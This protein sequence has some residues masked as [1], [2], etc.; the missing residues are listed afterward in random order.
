[1][2]RVAWMLSVCLNLVFMGIFT[3]PNLSPF[4]A[5]CLSGTSIEEKANQQLPRLGRSL[6]QERRR[7][8]FREYLE[9][10]SEDDLGVSLRRVEGSGAVT[11]QPGPSPVC[12]H[13]EVV[14]NFESTLPLLCYTF[15]SLLI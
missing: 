3:L 4:P 6:P 10:D 12:A 8:S 15:C 13:P 2:M 5:H 14:G 11:C 1:M 7:P 9:D